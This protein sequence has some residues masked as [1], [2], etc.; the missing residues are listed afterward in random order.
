MVDEHRQIDLLFPCFVINILTCKLLPIK[1]LS[2]ACYELHAATQKHAESILDFDFP[3]TM[4]SLDMKAS[5]S[6][7]SKLGRF[8][9]QIII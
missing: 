7:L 3:L 5:F 4:P 9:R 6:L 8:F 2:Y 1:A